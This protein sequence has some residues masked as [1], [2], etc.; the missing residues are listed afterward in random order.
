[1]KMFLY[2]KGLKD[3]TYF[4]EEQILRNTLDIAM[5]T[6]KY[7]KVYFSNESYHEVQG[8]RSSRF[9]FTELISFLAFST[10]QRCITFFYNN[11][12]III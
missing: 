9:H 10:K 2:Y 4:E 12:Y 8:I 6:V 7:I 5:Q 11:E 3:L 1:M